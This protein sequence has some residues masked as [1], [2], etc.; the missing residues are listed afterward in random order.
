MYLLPL[1]FKLKSSSMPTLTQGGPVICNTQ[2]LF[3]RGFQEAKQTFLN[4]LIN[5]PWTIDAIFKSFVRLDHVIIDLTSRPVEAGLQ[6]NQHFFI[7][8]S[9]TV[10]CKAAD[11]L[12]L[13]VELLY[14]SSSGP[15]VTEFGPVHLGFNPYRGPRRSR[16]VQDSLKQLSLIAYRL[17]HE[18]FAWS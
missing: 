9:R 18:S 5:L 10:I 15:I 17:G 2:L 16:L 11:V 7:G 12:E 3:R 8:H 6:S 14:F 1:S 13:F 4:C